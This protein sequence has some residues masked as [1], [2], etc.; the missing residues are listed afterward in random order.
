MG[1][2]TLGK[3]FCC[4]KP[5]CH[6]LGNAGATTRRDCLGDSGSR[7]A[8][9]TKTALAQHVVESL[10]RVP[11]FCDPVDCSP[12]G[13]S[14]HGISQARIV[15]C[16]FLL[17]GIFPTQG[18]N[19]PTSPALAGGFFATE[20]PGKPLAQHRCTLKTHRPGDFLGGPVVKTL[21]I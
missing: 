16:H 21:H 3:C 14:V 15:N 19:E 1:S 10:S 11:L 8:G 5:R 2:R 7:Q 20:P 4:P 9:S 13:S 6:P 18:L 12:L 17:Q